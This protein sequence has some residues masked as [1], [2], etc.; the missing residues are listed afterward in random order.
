MKLTS[1]SDPFS[2]KFHNISVPIRIKLK[3]RREITGN[4]DCYS[5]HS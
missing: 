4:E 5:V 3:K 2:S 1:N